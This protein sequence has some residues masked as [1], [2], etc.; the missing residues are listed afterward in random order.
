MQE[1]TSKEQLPLLGSRKWAVLLMVGMIA[2]ASACSSGPATSSVASLP[3]HTGTTHSSGPLTQAQG[4]Q[5]L[6]DFARCMRAHGVQMSDPF[7]RSGHA[8]LT[9]EIPTV[10]AATQPALNACNHFLHTIIAAKQAGAQQE[11]ATWL[12]ELA[13]YAQCM[14]SHDIS[15]LDPNAQGAL[16]LGN[17]P[18][19][20]DDFGRYTPQFRA[21]D[22]A[23]KHL[24]PAGVHDDGTGP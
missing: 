6:I 8:G 3:G 20:T 16:N 4:D 1:T 12:P 15:M 13:N 10:N 24:L 19:I 7:H 23:C 17:V 11:L 5:D 2:V 14:R 18:G 9:T 21:A 22:S